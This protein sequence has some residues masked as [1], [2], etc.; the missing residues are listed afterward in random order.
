MLSVVLAGLSSISLGFLL[1]SWLGHMRAVLK[2][3]H[4]AHAFSLELQ[5]RG[6]IE[7]P[8]LRA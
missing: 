8:V 3:E 2:G 5:R 1:L 4:L 6:L 7:G